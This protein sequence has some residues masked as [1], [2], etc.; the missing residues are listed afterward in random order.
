[1]S[2]T[3]EEREPLLG[4]HNKASESFIVKCKYSIHHKHL[5][6]MC[7]RDKF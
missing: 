6:K 2:V 4:R 3:L 5:S 7:I 1:M